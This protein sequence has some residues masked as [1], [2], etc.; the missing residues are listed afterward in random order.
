MKFG[1]FRS[2]F[3]HVAAG[4]FMGSPNSTFFGDS[5]ART[6]ARQ[7][8]ST[9]PR[10]NSRTIKSMIAFG[11][12]ADH[13]RTTDLLNLNTGPGIAIRGY[14]TEIGSADHVPFANRRAIGVIDVT[15]QNS[16]A[17]RPIT[18]GERSTD[19]LT[20]TSTSAS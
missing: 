12:Q 8:A 9:E 14:R 6:F 5:R 19:S 2:V 18:V 11:Q 20:P 3:V 16:W 15:S 1:P 10:R 7:V 4:K 13:R 17:D